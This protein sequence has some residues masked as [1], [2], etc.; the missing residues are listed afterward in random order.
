MKVQEMFGHAFDSYMTYAYPADE[1]MPVSCK[2]RVRGVTPSR[3][4]IDDALGR[5]GA[6]AAG[7]VAE[8]PNCLQCFAGC[9]LGAS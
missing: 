4:D 6:I 8:P 3:G 2:G 5:Y 7:F 9:K 1:L